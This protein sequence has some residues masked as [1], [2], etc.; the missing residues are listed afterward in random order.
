M[1]GAM[2]R[3]TTLDAKTPPSAASPPDQRERAVHAFRERHGSLRFAPVVVVIPAF[4]EEDAIGDVLEEVP[5]EACGL[6]VDTLVIDD[7]SSDRT[8]EAARAAGVHVAALDENS[9]QG[10]ALRL[11][12]RLAREHGA[13]YIVTLDADGQWEP[14]DV[15]TLLEPILADEADFVLGSRVLGRTETDDSFRQAGV[16][17]FA[18]LVRLLTGVRVTDTSSGV[19]AFRVEVTETVRQE[20]PQYQASELLVGAICQGYRIA[21]RPVVMHKRTAGHSKKGHNILYGLRYGRTLL[22]TWW[23]DRGADAALPAVEPEAVPRTVPARIAG[24]LAEHWGAVVVLTAGGVLRGVVVA[25]YDPFFWF[26]GTDGYLA[27]A[28]AVR[29]AEAHPWGYSGFLWLLDHGLGYREIVMVQHA[30]VLGLAALLYV[31]LVHRGVARWLATLAVGPLALSPLLANVEHHLLPEP[32]FLALVTAAPLALA[33]SGASPSLGVCAGAGLLTAAAGFMEL[34]G[35]VVIVPLAV[36]VI[37]HRAGAVRLATLLVAFAVP[38]GGYLVWMHQTHGVYAFSTWRGKHLYARVAPF[39]QCDRLGAL[40][41][42]QRLLC[43]SRPVEERPGPER[44]LWGDP[45][46]PVRTLPDSLVLG[47]ARKVIAHQPLDYLKAVGGGTAHAFYP[48]QRQRRREPCIGNWGFPDPLPGGCRADKVG[49]KVWRE[50]P[51]TV[52]RS[53]A[54]GLNRYARLDYPIG[55]AFVACLLATLLAIVRR[56]RRGEWLRRLDAGFFAVVGL[57]LT[58]AA[59]ATA[60]FSYRY[61]IPLYSTL[62][63][64]AALAVTHLVDIRRRLRQPAPVPA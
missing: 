31:F 4:N 53:L 59:I 32:V 56:P 5:H 21:E 60:N 29:P 34:A 54:H 19:R 58:I 43:D 2:Q 8:A 6:G 3:D 17:V 41:A 16:R 30:L 52:D 33:W 27:A 39:A 13:R 24:T 47:F 15:T 12:Y 38:L 63:V 10:S 20:E 35:L 11:G 36:Y 40:T 42:Q 61:T 9:G 23:R 1:T 51:V 37:C 50:H 62:P 28:A 18:F 57:A 25:A 48:G 26:P 46:A 45:D 55:P 64:A 14:T 7:G 49:T 22:R 44:Y